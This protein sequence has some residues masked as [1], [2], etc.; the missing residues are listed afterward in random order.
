MWETYEVGQLD[1][2]ANYRVAVTLERDE[3]PFQTGRVSARIVR[4]TTGAGG[5]PRRTSN[6]LTYQFDRSV[7]HA[8]VLVDNITILLENTPAGDYFVRIAI[9]DK[10]SG[11]TTSRSTALVVR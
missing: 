10:V 1:G 3:A 11:R 5:A 8:P 4:G 2:S 7:P 6:S 9:T